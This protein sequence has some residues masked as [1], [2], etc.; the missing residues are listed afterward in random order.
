MMIPNAQQVR[1][2]VAEVKKHY[3]VSNALMYC[4]YTADVVLFHF[5]DHIYL[6]DT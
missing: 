3:S 5:Y 4:V 2:M 1:I 6:R